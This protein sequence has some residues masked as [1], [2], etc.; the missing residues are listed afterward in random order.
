VGDPAFTVTEEGIR[1]NDVDDVELDARTRFS[2]EPAEPVND[3]ASCG[4][5][6]RCDSVERTRAWVAATGTPLAARR[7]T[8]SLISDVFAVPR[9]SRV[10]TSVF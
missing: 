1:L 10:G 6:R 5:D 2:S 9:Q 8:D 4:C 3:V 7:C